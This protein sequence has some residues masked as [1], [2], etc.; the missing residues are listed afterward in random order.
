MFL[1]GDVPSQHG[2]KVRILQAPV[3]HITFKNN[4]SECAWFN[5][6]AIYDEDILTTKE[7]EIMNFDHIEQSVILIHRYIEEEVEEMTKNGVVSPYS[8]I[9]I[10]GVGQGGTMALHY[11]FTSK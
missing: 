10:G 5:I 8:R 3:R 6:D 7:D 4:T 2:I 1:H 11:A 9:Y